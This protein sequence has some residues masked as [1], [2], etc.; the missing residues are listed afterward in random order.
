MSRNRQDDAYS[1]YAVAVI[2]SM[3]LVAA[4]V[5]ALPHVPVGWPVLAVNGAGYMLSV[6]VMAGGYDR[7]KK[8]LEPFHSFLIAAG[9]WVL[10]VGAFR[11]MLLAVA[12]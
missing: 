2:C 6:L 5:F 12:A 9:T 11:M 7:L 10:V 1:G 8:T 4:W 3:F